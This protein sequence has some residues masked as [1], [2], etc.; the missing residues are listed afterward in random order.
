MNTAAGLA[1]VFEHC[2]KYDSICLAISKIRGLARMPSSAQMTAASV[3]LI[4]H[5]LPIVPNS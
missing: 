2:H 1:L 4:G 3:A 5:A